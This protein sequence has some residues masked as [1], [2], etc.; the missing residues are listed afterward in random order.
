[1]LHL[2]YFEHCPNTVVEALSQGCPVVCT[3]V[4][5]TQELVKHYGYVLPESQNF[6]FTKPCDYDDPPDLNLDLQEPLPGRDSL[7][8]HADINIASCAAAYVR[9]FESIV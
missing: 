7:G 1:M 2:A 8:E 6:D 5:G 4:G 3:N 9:T